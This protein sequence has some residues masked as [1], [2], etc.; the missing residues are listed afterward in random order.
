LPLKR[1]EGFFFERFYAMFGPRNEKGAI[2]DEEDASG[3]REI[4][5]E[6]DGN[7][8]PSLQIVGGMRP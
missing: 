8:A 1:P 7:L 2:P 4:P 6:G 5:G 3:S